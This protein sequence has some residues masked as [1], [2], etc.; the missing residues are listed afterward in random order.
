MDEPPEW[1]KDYYDGDVPS[2]E[3]DPSGPIHIEN[4]ENESR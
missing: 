4:W 1:I 2:I 3:E